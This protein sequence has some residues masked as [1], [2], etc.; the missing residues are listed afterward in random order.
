MKLLFIDSRDSFT[1]NIIDYLH[2][3][4]VEE[5]R[6]I[7][8]YQHQELSLWIE[9]I[10]KYAPTHL[11]VGPGPGSP[12]D[13]PWI[14]DLII[15]LEGKIPVLGICLGH[16]LIVEAYKGE[17]IPS[18]NPVHGKQ[19]TISVIYPKSPLFEKFPSSFIVGRY[20][21]LVARSVPAPLRISAKVSAHDVLTPGAVMAVEH[22]YATTYGIQFHPE[23][24]LSD[25]GLTL[26]TN[27]LNIAP[28]SHPSI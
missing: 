8:S 17:V 13:Y 4:R 25:H 15:F 22:L 10:E 18:G 6:I 20:H 26:L 24:F 16:Q 9:E 27:F 7:D 28:T 19:S 12:S 1:Y 2:Q 11:I 23:S 5:I 21:S 14:Q 3:L